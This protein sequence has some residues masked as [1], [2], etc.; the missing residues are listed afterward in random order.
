MGFAKSIFA[1]DHIDT[2]GKFPSSVWNTR[3]VLKHRRFEHAT[4]Q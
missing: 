1:N 2:I 3:K 4:T